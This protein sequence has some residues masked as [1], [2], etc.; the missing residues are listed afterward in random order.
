MSHHSSRRLLIKTIGGSVVII[1]SGCSALN[2]S[3]SKADQTKSGSD[4]DMELIA[5]LGDAPYIAI[6]IEPSG[7]FEYLPEE[8]RIRTGESSTLPFPEWA[9]AQAA[10]HARDNLISLLDKKSLLGDG[11]AVGSATVDFSNINWKENPPDTNEFSQDGRFALI[12]PYTFNYDRDGNLVSEPNI[13]FNELVNET[14]REA[15]V[16]VVV[17]GRSYLATIPVICRQESIQFD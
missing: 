9:T 13:P 2:E 3:V 16:T 10:D 14:P 8:D 15:K 12:V 6:E 4:Q 11:V 17:S 1:M 7:N 5:Q